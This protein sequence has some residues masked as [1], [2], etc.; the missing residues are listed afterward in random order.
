MSGTLRVAARL[1]DMASV[2]REHGRALIGDI[3]HDQA[4]RLRTGGASIFSTMTEPETDKPSTIEALHAHSE[5]RDA[6]LRA[7]VR[8]DEFIEKAWL[9][10]GY[11]A[12]QVAVSA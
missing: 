7:H 2:E 6:H 11:P 12:P 5:K 9:L 4:N 8:A 1:E 10:E 3:L